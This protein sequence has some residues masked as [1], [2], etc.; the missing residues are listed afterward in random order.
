V[1]ATKMKCEVGSVTM[2]DTKSVFVL[3]VK[4][5]LENSEIAAVDG[6]TLKAENCVPPGLL[7]KSSVPVLSAVRIELPAMPAVGEPAPAVRTPVV[8]TAVKLEMLPEPLLAAKTLEGPMTG[9]LVPE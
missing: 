9:A 3:R 7:S 2:P 8:L 4:G 6:V 1:S 5:A